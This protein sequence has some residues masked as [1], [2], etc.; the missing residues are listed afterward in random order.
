MKIRFNE[1][2]DIP[3]QTR[4]LSQ[5]DRSKRFASFR[6]RPG[7][8]PMIALLEHHCM[9][10]A[11][12]AAIPLLPGNIL[13]PITRR[14]PGHWQISYGT[15]TIN[16]TIGN[17]GRM[18]LFDKIR[19]LGVAPLNHCIPVTARTERIIEMIR[20]ALSGAIDPLS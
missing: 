7:L 13:I 14:L 1:A 4:L 8:S 12:F 18:S 6:L 17:A 20:K 5:A 9:R 10:C 3:P 16:P 15:D 11:L 2:S 19:E